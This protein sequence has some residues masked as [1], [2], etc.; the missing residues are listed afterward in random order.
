MEISNLQLGMVNGGVG[1]HGVHVVKPVV[2][3]LKPV[4]EP[5]L[6][7]PLLLVEDLVL[8][9]VS[10]PNLVIQTNVVSNI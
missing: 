2:V 1:E 10:L 9:A 7:R 3:D 6:I 4:L 5:A 8:E